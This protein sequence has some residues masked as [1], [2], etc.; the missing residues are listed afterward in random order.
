MSKYTEGPWKVG[1][2]VKNNHTPRYV[3]VLA[4]RFK[5]IAKASYG[6][7]DEEAAA[8]AHLISAAP[9]LLE[10][11]EKVLSSINANCI[12]EQLHNDDAEL[13]SE[14]MADVYRAITKAKVQS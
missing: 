1:S 5:L 10:V 12:C 7:T 14:L 9:D 4:G 11:C 8:N 3:E 2:L 13:L 6:K